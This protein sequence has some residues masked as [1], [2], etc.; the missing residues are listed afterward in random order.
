MDIQHVFLISRLRNLD[1]K[2]PDTLLRGKKFF[3][4][5]CLWF[6][7]CLFDQPLLSAMTTATASASSAVLL[8]SS[9]VGA[10]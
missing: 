7:A 5:L 9:E 1:R 2:L 4:Q 3:W 10:N 8:A 6:V